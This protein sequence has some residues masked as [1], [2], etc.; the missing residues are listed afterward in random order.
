MPFSSQFALSLE[1]TRLI[2][3]HHV[4]SKAA[5]A[6]MSV[7][8]ELRHSGSD[9]VTEE[10]LTN[11]FGRCRIAPELASS[12]KTIMVQ[13]SKQTPL[14]E[15]ITLQA[16]PGP[17]VLRALRDPA[18]F[19]TVVQ[20]SFLTWVCEAGYLATALVE[21]LRKRVAIDYEDAT[22]FQATPDHRSIL[23]VLQAC[24]RQTAGF[25]WNDVLHAVAVTL[26]YPIDDNGNLSSLVLQGALDMFPMIQSFPEHCFVHIQIP[27]HPGYRPY[28]C[29][30]VVWTH[31][32]L[33]LSVRIQ[34]H[35][36]P[37]SGKASTCHFGSTTVEQVLIQEVA[38]D[39]DESITLLDAAKDILLAIEPQPGIENMLIGSIRRSSIKGW[40]SVVLKEYLEGLKNFP[41]QKAIIEDL[42][43]VV[44]AF[45]LVVCEHL[46]RDVSDG[47]YDPDITA[48]SMQARRGSIPFVITE[49]RLIEA[50]K[51][52]FDNPKIQ[53]SDVERYKVLYSKQALNRDLHLP[54]T[55][56]AITR[57]YPAPERYL[58]ERD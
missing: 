17:T 43:L 39:C 54:L 41:P 19:S 42:Q 32:I 6:V 15:S 48:E 12:F 44:C 40:G 47:S 53:K 55:L 25:N 9:I 24:E 50:S 21:C 8:R 35:P 16:G 18:Y 30:I 26:G 20:I 58:I 7:A 10:D 52:L 49:Q 22:D 56:E 46:V 31:H 45:A 23:D 34:F 14:W 33:G 13:S 37:G 57:E 5:E 1:V 4:V 28:V 29:A 11:V 38:E 3:L 27:K 2:P 36:E 51:F